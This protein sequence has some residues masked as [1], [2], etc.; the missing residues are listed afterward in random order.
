MLCFLM[1]S[2][3]RFQSREEYI[4]QFDLK[5]LKNHQVHQSGCAH[6]FTTMDYGLLTVA[7]DYKIT[8]TPSL[9]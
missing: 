9:I 7:I 3:N 6:K 2:K 1:A 5:I 8:R 4:P